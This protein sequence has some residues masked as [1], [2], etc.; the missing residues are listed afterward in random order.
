MIS[1]KGNPIYCNCFM[2]PLKKWATSGGVKL[3]GSCAGPP[4]LADEQLQAVASL[5]L[6]CRSRGEALEEEEEEE[7]KGNNTVTAKPRRPVKCPPNCEC[8]VSVW[9]VV[10]SLFFQFRQILSGFI[11]FS[12]FSFMKL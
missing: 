8:D 10:F 4:H 9:D 1:I 3:L 5:D 11:T 6:R 2:R 7:D 12:P